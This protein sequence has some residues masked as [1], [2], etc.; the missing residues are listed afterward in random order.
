[1]A[2]QHLTYSDF[3]SNNVHALFDALAALEGAES[4]LNMCD[5]AG[6]FDNVRRL[7]RLAHDRVKPV[8]DALDT[9]S[10]QGTFAHAKD[11]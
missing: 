5:E 1:M 9:T 10:T 4:L 11:D 7:V 6:E 8:I 2:T 3:A